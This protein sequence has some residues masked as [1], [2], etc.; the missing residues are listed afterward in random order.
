MKARDIKTVD[1]LT[2]KWFDKINGNT[3]FAQIITINRGLKSHTEFCNGFQY[4]YG[5]FDYFAAKRIINKYNL[6]CDEFE[7]LRRAK[8]CNTIIN[9]CKKRELLNI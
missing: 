4:G 6:K 8:F 2:K 1:V 9:G 3:Y 5:S 7:L